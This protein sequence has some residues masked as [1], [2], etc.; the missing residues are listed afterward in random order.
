[1][2]NVEK[3]I[4]RIVSWIR[5][6]VNGAGAKGVVIGLS[7]GID[8]AVVATLCVRALGKENVFG[9]N[10]PCESVE[11]ARID[12]EALSQNLGIPPMINISCAG[13]YYALLSGLTIVDNPLSQLTKANIK[14]RLRM[15]TLY[16]IAGE[17]SCLVAG[18]GNLSELAIGYF[19][20][21]GDGGVD[22]EPLGNFYKTEVYQIAAKLPEIPASIISKPPSADLWEGQTDEEEIGMTYAEL[23]KIL[24]KLI[25]IKADTSSRVKSVYNMVIK[26]RHK[27]NA[28]PR[29]DRLQEM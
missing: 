9:V 3:E 2:F 7:G 27:N 24:E 19:T 13:S 8:S 21:Y 1:M 17:K 25:N 20:K 11:S 29:Y 12:A 10:I 6:Y 14:A 5:D 22:F 23:D 18:T 16:A 26:N 4:E 28:P 15:T